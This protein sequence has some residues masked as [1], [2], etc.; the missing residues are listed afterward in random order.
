M[1]QSSVYA[2]A[3]ATVTLPNVSTYDPVAT[4]NW[5]YMQARD[6]GT[7]LDLS[8]LTTV[9]GNGHLAVNA[10]DGG[11]VD[12]SGIT[13]TPGVALHVT[14]SGTGSGGIGAVVDLNA[15]TTLSSG[16]SLEVRDDGTIL[17]PNLTTLDESEL[18]VKGTGVI[19]TTPITNADQSSIYAHAGATVTLPNVSTYDPVATYNW[20]YMQARDEG[21]VLDLSTLTTVAGNGHLAV[22]AYD[23]GKVDLSGITETPGVALHVT[24]SGA[25]SGGIG[26]V[27]DLNALATLSSGGSLEVR[28]D[29]TVLV[30]NLTVLS[31]ATLTIRGSGTIDT[32]PFTNVD[33]SSVYAHAGATVTL[34][35]V[36]TYDPV[37]TYNWRY[38]Q[39]RD[40]GTV[41]DLSTLTAVAGNGHLAVNAYDGGKVDLSGITETPGVALHVTTSG[42][43]S[44][45]TGAVVDLNALTTLSSGGSLE[46]RDDGTILAPNLTTL[47]ESELTVKGTGVIDTTPITNAD[48]SSVYAH[49]GATVTLP[50]VSTYDPVATYNWR[51]MQ[52]RDEGTVLDLSTLTTVA[53]NGHLAVNAYDGGK[54]D[55]SGIT[56]T[57]GVALHVTASGAGSGGIGAVVDLN[58]L[59]TLS[60]GGSLEVRDDGT[61]LVPNLTTLDESELTVK[62]TGVI[63]TTPITNA[64]QSSVYA[65]QGA[66]VTLPNVSTYDPVAAYNRRYMQ[67]RGEGSVL[68][69]STLTT[70][71]GNGHL[72]LNA[73]DGGKV[74]LSG[75]TETL[76]VALHVTARGIG[77]ASGR[78]IIDLS[79]LEVTSSGSEFDVKDGGTVRLNPAT[80]RLVGTST[81]VDAGGTLEVGTLELADGSKLY[82]TM[83]LDSTLVNGGIVSPGNRNDEMQDLGVT[84]DY[85]QTADGV[86]EI[87]VAGV[88]NTD[89]EALQFD[90]LRVGMDVA[91]GGTFEVEMLAGFAGDYGDTLTIITAGG[92][93]S[94]FFDAVECTSD[95]E[96]KTFEIGYLSDQITVT[97]VLP[98]DL[99]GDGFVG[100]SDLDRVRGNWNQST[101]AGD[102][103]AGDPTGDGFVGSADLDIIRAAWNDRI[104]S[105]ASV[106]EPSMIALLTAGLIISAGARRR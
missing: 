94:G 14:T 17:A 45:G 53:G 16:G 48:Q 19:D 47:D 63:D 55:L 101:R 8:T 66:T 27:V 56:E 37:A 39:A 67:A 93:V 3:G 4:Y 78:A 103:S 23:G 72:A 100:S 90:E 99:D 51:Y 34:P 77:E 62:G 57:P 42:T 75:I 40:E 86:L 64:D 7:V 54:V 97:V 91:V 88:D 58:A 18:T 30:P 74:D 2:N 87:E 105:P 84:G 21:T 96:K 65:E 35:N 5:R 98:G 60:S 43:G 89:P 10:Y 13:E 38:M 95:V 41:L 68:D 28:D 24:A 12:L 59:A 102:F 79:Q 6:E 69:L 9:A 26:A 92:S 52:A 80:T 61:I 85:T 32:T 36:S 70:V 11:K 73:Y 76:G 31:K 33:Q 44:G 46:V 71:A 104:P 81:F 15:L 50:N 22:N 83:M 106:P 1:D 82:G 29:G 49:A 25:G 20:R